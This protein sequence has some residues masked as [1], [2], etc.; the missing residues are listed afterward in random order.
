MDTTEHH[1]AP[2]LGSLIDAARATAPGLARA[3]AKASK[4]DRRRL[5]IINGKRRGRL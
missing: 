1:E 4:A 3:A 5:D 2:T